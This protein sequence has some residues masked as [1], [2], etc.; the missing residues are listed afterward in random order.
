MKEA[1]HR[2][3]ETLQKPSAK[4]AVH[5]SNQYKPSTHNN[6]LFEHPWTKITGIERFIVVDT[7]SPVA[8]LDTPRSQPGLAPRSGEVLPRDPAPPARPRSRHNNGS[9]TR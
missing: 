2:V 5:K 6:D 4:K 7:P 9:R 3:I 1:L 8:G